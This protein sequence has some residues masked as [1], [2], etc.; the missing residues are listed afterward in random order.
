ME[1]IEWKLLENFG[2]INIFCD[3]ELFLSRLAKMDKQPIYE[4]LQKIPNGKVTTYKHIAQKFNTHPRVV[5][6]VMRTNEN[7][8]I[9]PCYKVVGND[10]KLVWYNSKRWISEKAEKL[11]K[12]GIEIKDGKV[13]EKYIWNG[14]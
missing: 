8:E 13:L 7:P 2:D 1:R 6:M 9:Y 11:K 4:Y 10:G 14:N 12:D 3:E 5:G